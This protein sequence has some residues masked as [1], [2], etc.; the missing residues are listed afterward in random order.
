MSWRFALVNKRLAEIYF[1]ETKNGPRIWGHCYVNGNE[2]K[3]KQELK[4]IKQDT[5]KFKFSYR[6]HKYLRKLQ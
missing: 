1:K 5:A 3:T 4:W 6:N 2:Y